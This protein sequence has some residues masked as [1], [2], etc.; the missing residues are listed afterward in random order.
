V[1]TREASRSDDARASRRAI[2]ARAPTHP[3]KPRDGDFL[4][5]RATRSI[6]RSIVC[7]LVICGFMYCIQ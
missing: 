2:A 6:D 3:D 7:G 1:R 4:E 5:I